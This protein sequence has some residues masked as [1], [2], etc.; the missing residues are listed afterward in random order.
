M[1][2]KR[3]FYVCAG[4]F[5]LA[6]AFALG[7][8]SVRASGTIECANFVFSTGTAVVD[9]RIVYQE[10]NHQMQTV[11]DPI[12]GSSPVIACAPAGAVLENGDVWHT[13][14]SGPGSSTDW[15][16]VGNLLTGKATPATKET[17]GDLK[18]RYR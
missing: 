15:T 14:Y 11:P 1:A 10:Y 13:N 18:L 9:R 4:L 6:G 3:F 2:A 16:L 8:Q 7:A 5:L 17:W 12:P